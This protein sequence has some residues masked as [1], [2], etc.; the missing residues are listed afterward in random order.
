VGLA[1]GVEFPATRGVQ[2]AEWWREVPGVSWNAPE[3]GGSDVHDRLDHPVVH[4][5]WFD[6]LS[7]CAWA[8]VRLATE[9]EWEYAARGG[10]EG[11]RFPWGDMPRP[12]ASIG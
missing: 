9:P 11:R 7:Y 2:G 4:V 12:V 8:G 10:L 5:S 3:G 6:A 1:V